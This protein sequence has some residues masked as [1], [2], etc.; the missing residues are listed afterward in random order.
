MAVFTRHR[1][2]Q[3][4]ERHQKDIPGRHLCVCA[5]CGRQ[6]PRENEDGY[7]DTSVDTDLVESED[8]S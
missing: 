4:E 5:Q 6:F 7:S 3:Q 2:K 1:E 8:K